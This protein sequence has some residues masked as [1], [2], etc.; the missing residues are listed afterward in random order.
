MEEWSA[1]EAN[2]FEEAIEKYGKDFNDI[3]QDFLPWKALKDIV[4]YYYMWKTTDRYVQSK[5]VKAAEAESRL[6]QVYIPNYNK[7]NPNLVGP[8][9]PTGQP[10]KG[11]SPCESCETD[12]SPQWYAWGP[13]QMQMRLCADC[14]TAWKKNGGLKRDH[15]WETY[16][17][18]GGGSK[19]LGGTDFVQNATGITRGATLPSQQSHSRSAFGSQQM[20]KSGRLVQGMPNPNGPKTRVAFFLHTTLMT[21]VARR[22]ASR[23]LF[24]VRKSARK[25]FLPIAAQAIKQNCQS[26]DPKEILKVAKQIKGGRLPQGLIDALS[27]VRP[28][29]TS[30][31]TAATTSPGTA[32]LK[33]P[34]SN[35]DSKTTP[36]QPPAKAPRQAAPVAMVAMAQQQMYS[37][38]MALTEDVLYLANRSVK[39]IRRTLTNRQMRK[40]ARGPC[41]PNSAVTKLLPSVGFVALAA[42][43]NNNVVVVE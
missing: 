16:D 37:R 9:N 43:T 42:N 40:V 38:W 15:E 23:S 11:T 17:K 32:S 4:E 24:N 27:G 22:L 3:R 19:P 30:L 12:M 8:P 20:G 14:W 21:R 41:K 10:V 7:P 6:K 2:L 29:V 36:P 33:R 34:V 18:T 5:R 1:A 28:A 13:A 39:R 25:P 26:R 35:G 31:P